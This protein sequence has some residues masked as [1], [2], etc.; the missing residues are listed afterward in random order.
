MSGKLLRATQLSLGL[1]ALLCAACAHTGS[2][3][4]TVILAGS[5]CSGAPP[6][7]AA[8][9][10]LPA[11]SAN[12]QPLV[13]YVTAQPGAKLVVYDLQAG[14][15][16]FQVPAKLRSRPQ[17]LRD[18]VVAVAE[19]D[20][21]DKLVAYDLQTGE[22]R[23]AYPVPRAS[24]LGAVQVGDN[25]IF[26]SSSLSFKP[27]ERGSTVTALSTKSGA[28]RWERNV[29]YALSRPSA[30]AGR[31]YVISDHADVWA[32][33]ADSGGSLGCSRLGTE[34]VEWLQAHGDKL[35]LG[36]DSARAVQLTQQAPSELGRLQLKAAALPGQPLLQPSAYQS[37]PAER[38]AY[39]RVAL[40]TTLQVAD[41]TPS[42]A[43]GRYFYTFYKHLFAFDAEGQLQWAHKLDADSAELRATPASVRLVTES[44]QVLWFSA[45]TGAVLSQ[46]Q[47]PDHL[48]SADLS[49]ASPIGNAGAPARHLRSELRALALDTDARLLPSRKLVVSALAASADPDASRDLLDVYTEPSAPK[50]LQTHVAR[51]LADRPRG[52]EHLVAALAG[53]YNFLTGAPPP[54]L[55]AIVPGLVTNNEQRA[56]PRLIDRLFDP[57]TR[58]P[59]LHLLVTTIAKLGGRDAKKPLTDFLAL[60]HAD[61]SLAEDASSLLA[62]AQALVP[63]SSTDPAKPQPELHALELI[64]KDPSTLPAL[65][66]RLVSLL[67]TTAPAPEQAVAAAEPEPAPEPPIQERLSDATITSVFSAHAGELHE[68]IA[69]E[70]ARNAG[71]RALRFH[72]VVENTGK[73]SR[74]SVWP[75]RAEL[76]ACMQPKLEQLQFPAFARG[77]RLASYTLALR[78]DAKRDEDASSPEHSKPF[79]F[80]AQLRG[81]GAQVDAERAPWWHNQ[82]PLFLSVEEPSKPAAQ[83]DAKQAPVESQSKP[84]PAAIGSEAKP[85]GETPTPK[86]EEKPATDQWWLP[87]AAQ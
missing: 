45:D 78:A 11:V 25:L 86:P 19:R 83:S 44:G 7:T 26:T 72:F 50:D 39:G 66:D 43:G 20:G 62:A 59:E 60:Y 6:L 38:S 9:P 64:S 8:D 31:V 49:A 80:I 71:L 84:A 55:A 53:D 47:L 65:K 10:Q 46:L 14:R 73:L 40:A 87:G 16:R 1:F 58:L 35:L 36:T 33:Q 30:G 12:E 85:T 41:N 79:W 21:Q 63:E 57:D 61:S 2:G 37:V 68:C 69:A 24:W 51:V 4:S 48:T 75:Q 67:A 18:V 13:A 5:V 3:E 22:L 29:P 34:P 74:L 76:I 23:A 82:N 56:L 81:V 17:L 28:Q 77:R 27:S 32:L 52:S 15:V 70:L 42:V 54:P